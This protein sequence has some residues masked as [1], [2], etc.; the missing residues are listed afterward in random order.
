M[1]TINKT[2]HSGIE[3]LRI[4][5]MI[6]V[7]VLHYNGNGEGLEL[8]Q[9]VPVNNWILYFLHFCSHVQ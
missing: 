7:V 1:K 3:L 8:S 6:G 4:L 2:R 9:S 5:A